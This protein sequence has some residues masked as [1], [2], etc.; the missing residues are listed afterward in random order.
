MTIDNIIPDPDPTSPAF[1][2]NSVP[3]SC[4][5]I[6]AVTC[7][8]EGNGFPNAN[9]PRQPNPGEPSPANCNAAI[10]ALWDKWVNQIDRR[11]SSWPTDVSPSWEAFAPATELQARKYMP[12]SPAQWWN[13]P[14]KFSTTTIDLIGGM[15]MTDL[16]T[17]DY[18]AI[19]ARF[20]EVYDTSSNFSSGSTVAP[21]HFVRAGEM[22]TTTKGLDFNVNKAELYD[23]AV[24][25]SSS[26]PYATALN[27]FGAMYG[28]WDNL[29][30]GKGTNRKTVC[31]G[32]SIGPDSLAGSTAAQNSFLA[33]TP[34]MNTST[35]NPWIWTNDFYLYFQPAT[36]NSDPLAWAL[37]SSRY[38][39]YHG[40][41]AAQAASNVNGAVDYSKLKQKNPAPG[42]VQDGTYTADGE[43]L[44]TDLSTGLKPYVYT[45]IQN[46]T[47]SAAAKVIWQLS[48]QSGPFV[49][50]CGVEYDARPGNA[51]AGV[52]PQ[53]LL[54][55]TAPDITDPTMQDAKYYWP[56][57]KGMKGQWY[58]PGN[59]ANAGFLQQWATDQM[60]KP[61][62]NSPDG[63]QIVVTGST[64]DNFGVFQ[65]ICV[66]E[67]AWSRMAMD[68]RG[69]TIGS[70]GKPISGAGIAN[71]KCDDVNLG[72]YELA[73]IPLSWY[74][75]AAPLPVYPYYT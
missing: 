68:L 25:K 70:D 67:R 6:S 35:C 65:D 69:E 39:L 31:D 53:P 61:Q 63:P 8:G 15:E 7:D 1:V 41:W 58:G 40:Q 28:T 50:N 62:S 55:F 23:L 32:D 26:A 73:F 29:V 46:L 11:D 66:I 38:D 47:P 72:C 44:W 13:L 30:G 49:N 74:D 27:T 56:G 22:K 17:P 20:P 24:P 18:D 3:A 33:F 5:Q 59:S 75:P 48:T 52:T 51:K 16:G 45:Q 43:L 71:V 12:T 57:W 14:C 54:T 60:L 42:V 37:E 21:V 34:L 4:A 10:K 2:P 9:F 19:N 36:Q 64:E